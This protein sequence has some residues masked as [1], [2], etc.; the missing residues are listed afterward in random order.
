MQTFK[1]ALVGDSIFDSWGDDCPEMS[2]ELKRLYSHSDFLIENHGLAGSRAGHALWR[3]SNDYPKDGRLC[4][5][6]SM[7]NPHV[8]V[9]DSFAYSNR[10]DGP[11]G[12]SEYRDVLRRL[13]DEIRTTTASQILFCLSIP[14]HRDRFLETTP[15]YFNTSR[16]TRQRMADDVK[17][18]LDEARRIA[19]DEGWPIADVAIDIEKR[20]LAGENMRQ[21]INQ[22][23]SLHPSRYGFQTMATLITRAIDNNRMIEEKLGG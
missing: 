22:S 15:S 1:I 21:F 20:V 6:L 17:L 2:Q 7:F 10:T 16:A 19:Q 5:C 4:R 11:E 9:I 12:M 13:V 14:P 18:Y 3:V 8:T 23:D